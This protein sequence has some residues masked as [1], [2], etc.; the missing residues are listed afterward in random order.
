MGCEILDFDTVCI[1]LASFL[2]ES[3]SLSSV[4][5]VNE[6]VGTESMLR[7]SIYKSKNPGTWRR[8]PEELIENFRMQDHS[9]AVIEHKLRS[10]ELHD[11]KTTERDCDAQYY[12]ISIPG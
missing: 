8:P 10:A 11:S 3:G 9:L 6:D 5:F 2:N 12:D 4:D 7:Q 1:V